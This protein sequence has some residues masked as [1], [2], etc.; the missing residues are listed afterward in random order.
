M[1]PVKWGSCLHDLS[2]FT[3]NRH[4]TAAC[5]GTGKHRTKPNPWPSS[6]TFPSRLPL[7]S[8]L[9]GFN[10]S[11]IYNSMIIRCFSTKLNKLASIQFYV[12]LYI[13]LKTYIEISLYRWISRNI[14]KIYIYI[15]IGNA[16]SSKKTN[17]I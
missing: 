15:Y 12:S 4:C 2:W 6:T 1:T 3:C 17:K 16:S 8:R 13:Y 7:N 10:N 11:S 14:L 5:V 9:H